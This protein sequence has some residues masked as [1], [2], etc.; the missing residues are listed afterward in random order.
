[1]RRCAELLIVGVTTT[2]V[3]GQEPAM[4]QAQTD[5]SFEGLETVV[6]TSQ[7]RSEDAQRV[8]LSV[9]VLD[10]KMLAVQG[11][12][13][14]SD[15]ANAVPGFS[16]QKVSGASYPFLRG[17]GLQSSGPWQE[18]PVSTYIDGVYYVNPTIN[19]TLL[20]NLER[21]E[22]IK[23]PQGTLFGRN[24]TGGVVSYVTKEPSHTPSL[25]VSMGFGSYST[26]STSLYGTTGITENLAADIA[27]AAEDQQEGWGKNLFDGTDAHKAY[28]Y[29]LRSK[30]VWTPGENTKLTWIADYGRATSAEAG[31]G[32]VRGVYP[33]ITAGPQHVGGFYDIYTLNEAA[34]RSTQ[35]GVSMNAQFDMSW[36]Q[37]LSITAIRRAPGIV[38]GPDPFDVPLVAS[39]PGL[40]QIPALR[41]S[42][43]GESFNRTTTQEFQLMSPATSTIR[44]VGGVFMLWDASGFSEKNDRRV[45]A[46]G[47][48]L[49]NRS[50][51]RQ[52]TESYSAFAEATFPVIGDTTRV[53]GGVRYT[54]DHRSV[55]GF[56]T[57]N[58]LANPNVYTLRP[59]TT[60]ADNPVPS[61]TWRKPTYKLSLEQDLA[62]D[63]LAYFTFSTGFQSAFYTITNDANR[64]PLEPTTLDAYEV[65]LKSYFLDNRVRL[66]VSAFQY[67]LDN[68]VV[69]A[70]ANGSQNQRNAAESRIRGV[71]LDM[72]VRPI[73][74]LTIT[75]AVGYLEPIYTKYPNAIV[76]VPLANGTGYTIAAGDVSGEQLQ[77]SEKLMGTATATYR[78]PTTI[79]DFLLSGTAAYHSGTHY[80][81]QDL[82][83]QPSYN[84]FNASI[85][86]ESV[87][88]TTAVKVWGQN[89]G[90]E[91]YVAAFQTGTTVMKYTPAEPRTYGVR[92]GYHWK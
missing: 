61:K 68:V 56:G 84:L 47:P 81:T 45:L 59:G 66:N 31:N 67:D 46:A 39:A 37:F 4:G 14:V 62:D 65:G 54:S 21:V 75:A 90:D 6:V 64:P 78:I 35:Y 19:Q 18:A 82:N 16:I 69:S 1:M 44:W 49:N 20:N 58:T 13:N 50:H 52:D 63:V 11:I 92:F 23:G 43:W 33:F 29:A 42:N 38:E 36:A 79:G 85:G 86:W 70:F 24:A 12:E 8:P 77:W 80:D 32:S 15:L 5:D 89:L 73:R 72:S 40:G 2:I 34:N 26:Y 55:E 17:L 71:D 88:G 57:A 41:T 87:S 28:K 83:T 53:T 76:Y 7:K 91:E 51:T 9:A 3:M 60:D 10:S 30:W 22:V 48:T 25:D 74:D 27:I